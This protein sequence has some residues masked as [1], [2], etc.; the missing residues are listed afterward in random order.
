GAA[1]QTEN[2]C[3]A[4]GEPSEVLQR[5]AGQGEPARC[6]A[7][8]GV[9][10][11]RQRAGPDRGATRVAVVAGEDRLAG[12]ILPHDAG[13]GDDAAKGQG[14]G[15]VDGER[16]IVDDVARDRPAA[17]AVAERQRAGADRGVA[18]VAVVAAQR[19]G[20]GADLGEATAAGDAAGKRGAGVVVAGGQ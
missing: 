11:D 12:A 4:A 15:A 10:T 6:G 14:G 9:G 20:A 5:A 17:A 18:G 16:S 1:A 7:E 3:A 19:E 8:I 2:H 13:P